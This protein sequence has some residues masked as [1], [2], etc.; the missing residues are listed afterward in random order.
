[1]WL[2]NSVA[3][4][5]CTSVIK[6]ALAPAPLP[7]CAH[8]VSVIFNKGVRIINQNQHS[9]SRPAPE[10][11]KGGVGRR[12]RAIVESSL[13]DLFYS[14]P[15]ISLITFMPETKAEGNYGFHKHSSRGPLLT[16]L[17]TYPSPRCAI[18]LFLLLPA[19]FVFQQLLVCST[20]P[21][22]FRSEVSNVGLGE[23]LH[24]FACCNEYLCFFSI[25]SIK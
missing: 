24:G 2:A 10:G 22:G 23:E 20:E 9:W 11:K 17:F 25:T 16:A 1:M 5:I 21:V 14:D 8:G 19:Q 7:P 13:S 4:D 12:C 6:Q 18:T 3:P 15:Q